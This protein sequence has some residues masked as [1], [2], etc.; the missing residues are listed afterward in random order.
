[1]KEKNTYNEIWNREIKKRTPIYILGVFFQ[2]ITQILNL[3]APIII[4]NI[5][6]LLLKNAPKEEIFYQSFLLMAVGIGGLLPRILYRICYFTNARIADT[7][8]REKVIRHLQKVKPEYYEKEEKGTFLAYLSHELLFFARKSFGNLYFY[9][10]DIV[11]APFLT[12]IV[13]ANTINPIIAISAIPLILI[14]IIYIVIQYKK[15]N[16]KLENSREVYIELS[17]MIEQNT[18]CFS[19]IKL[20]NQQHNQKETFKKVNQNTKV[21]DYEIGIIKNKTSNGMNILF[22]STHIVGFALGLILAY[23][24]IITLGELTAYLSCLEFTL[25]C[26]ISALPKFLTGLGYY[27][28]TRNRYNYFYHLDTYGN[29]GKDLTQIDQIDLTNLTYSYD[30][31]ID[32]LKNIN[33][34]IRKGEKIGIIGQVGS[35]KT[36]LMNIIAGFYELPDGMI[37]INGID[38]NEYKPDDIFSSI[39][40]A[41][42]KNIILDENIENNVTVNGKLDEKRLESAIKNVEL[43]KDIEQMNEGIKTKLREEGNRLS[44]GQKQRISIARNLYN[45]R[46]VNIFDDTLSALDQ[47]TEDRVLKNILKVSRDETVIVVSNRVSHMEQL[48]RVYILANGTIEDVGTH[49]EL[50]ERNALYQ[51]FASF[52]KEG[53]LV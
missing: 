10:S 12:V 38:K 30:G 7:R 36:T 39:G 4:G 25:G 43:G 19:L 41:M 51:E 15:L 34:T 21:S 42:Q 28:Q 27:K 6:D 35:G 47:E 2:A 14:A 50:L 9:F 33:M 53:E 3:I 52:E 5:L 26:V 46:Q 45:L 31:K 22:A 44:G 16:Q 24:K 13:V 18:S 11:V 48:D 40:Y 20:Y 23:L 37:K 32:I 8:L 1:M 17:K 49:K 29:I